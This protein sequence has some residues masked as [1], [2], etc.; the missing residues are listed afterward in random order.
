MAKPKPITLETVDPDEYEGRN[1][2]PLLLVGE[3]PG[4]EQGPQGPEGPQ[5]PKG[6]TGAP[7]T[8]G[9]DG[10]QGPKGDKGDTGAPGADGFG[11]EAQY[12]DIISRLEA[13]EAAQA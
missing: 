8:D 11:T 6:D 12:N 2:K 5:G 4:G 1:P 10:A 13:L 3:I 7:G 9:A